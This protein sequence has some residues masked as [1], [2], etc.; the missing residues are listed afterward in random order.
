ML[1]QPGVELPGFDGTGAPILRDDQ[2]VF[3]GWAPHAYEPFEFTAI[4]FDRR[5]RREFYAHCKTEHLPY[6]LWV[7]V[8]LI[9]FSHHLG[10]QIAVYSDDA[11]SKWED[12]INAV[13]AR[14]GYGRDFKLS[15]D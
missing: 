3:N 2:I 7:K 14:L 8:V 12:A 5:G 15:L 13:V 4:E 11:Q 1:D 9:V 6:D 10:E